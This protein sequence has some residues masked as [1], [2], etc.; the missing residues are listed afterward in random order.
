MIPQYLVWGTEELRDGVD[1]DN[2]GFFARLPNDPIHPKTSQP[3]P[4]DFADAIR[5]SGAKEAVLILLSS[6]LSGTSDSARS[7]QNLVDIPLHVVDSLSVSIG[8][9]WQA[10][11]AAKVRDQGG[12]VGEIIAAADDVRRRIGRFFFTVDTLEFLHRG[13]RI[14]GAAKLVGTALQ[15][16]PMLVL[17]HATGRVEPG[18]RIR[19]RARALQRIVD[20]TFEQVDLDRP[21]HVAVMHGAAPDDAQRLIE[22]VKAR[23]DPVELLAGKVSPIIGVHAGPGVIGVGAYND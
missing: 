21:L 5:A 11:A 9:G 23:C 16:K 18:E 6:Q 14:G 19:T 22:E 13:G 2:D 7:A 12:S 4:T 8:L 3:T 20:A 15:L 10:L 17:D 1:I